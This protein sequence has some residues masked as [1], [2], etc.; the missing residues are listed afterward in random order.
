MRGNL[1]SKKKIRG[2]GWRSKHAGRN[3]LEKE[4]Q[5]KGT[6]VNAQEGGSGD[7]ILKSWRGVEDKREKLLDT[8]KRGNRPREYD[9][10]RGAS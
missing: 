6:G 4:Q 2:T 5:V 3:Q 8:K 7:K 9:D 10:L 1:P